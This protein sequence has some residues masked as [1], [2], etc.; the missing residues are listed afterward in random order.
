MVGYC[1]SKVRLFYAN[2]RK[3][4]LNSAKSLNRHQI[5]LY[6]TLFILSSPKIDDYENK[7][8]L[9]TQIALTLVL[10]EVYK[11]HKLYPT[12]APTLAKS[13]SF[14]VGCLGSEA[15]LLAV[16]SLFV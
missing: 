13:A 11:K 6:F 12:F 4:C 2:H 7:L 15:L 8:S 9:T 3:K 10:A 1:E 14:W 16:L 5:F